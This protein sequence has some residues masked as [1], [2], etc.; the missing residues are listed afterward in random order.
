MSKVMSE[1]CLTSTRPHTHPRTP[2]ERRDYE[3][4]LATLLDPLRKWL[5]SYEVEKE[6][7]RKIQLKQMLD[8]LWQRIV[9]K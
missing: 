3:E 7:V 6:R 4:A 9:Q 2:E 8:R 5:P 1:R